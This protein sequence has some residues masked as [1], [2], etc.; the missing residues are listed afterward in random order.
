[1]GFDECFLY[2]GREEDGLQRFAFT[3]RSQLG[4]PVL[5]LLQCGHAHYLAGFGT[6]TEFTETSNQCREESTC[7]NIVP[8][9]F[10]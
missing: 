4:F 3:L 7:L 10:L 8:K 9:L 6:K 2:D 5:Q 1:M